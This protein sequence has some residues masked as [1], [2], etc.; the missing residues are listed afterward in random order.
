MLK[1]KKVVKLKNDITK[2]DIRK[3]VARKSTKGVLFSSVFDT[4]RGIEQNGA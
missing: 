1:P 2:F 4:L 3:H